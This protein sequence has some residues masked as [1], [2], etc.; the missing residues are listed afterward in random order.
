MAN[1]TPPTRKPAKKVKKTLPSAWKITRSA[2][3]TIWQNRILFL[4][5]ALIYGLLTLVLV[6]LASN[7]D[8]T[9]L[10][11]SLKGSLGSVGSTLA[12]FVS[13]IGSSDSSNNAAGAYQFMLGLIA[14]LAIIWALR[15]VSAGTAVRIR[16]AYYKGMYP[17]IPFVLILLVISLQL[18]PLLVGSAIYAQVMTNGIAVSLVEKIAWA[19]FFGATALASLYM[20]VSSIFALYI[21]TLPD[22]GPIKALRSARDLVKGRRWLLLRKV[23][24]LPLALVILAAIV[25]L[26]FII[27]LTALAQAVFFVIGLFVLVVMHS[28]LY[29]LYRELINE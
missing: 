6:G 12:V 11:Q 28:Y 13:L 17:L 18:L 4:G 29:T 1:K 19:I 21:V 27:W 9:S 23:L 22:M 25:M 2:L 10:K 14:S 20:V 5:I 7:T 8:I 24:F 3:D 15:Q 16:D 26:P